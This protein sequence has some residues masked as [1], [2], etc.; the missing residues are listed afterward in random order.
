MLLAVWIGFCGGALASDGEVAMDAARSLVGLGERAAGSPGASAAQGWAAGRLEAMG[1]EVRR[2]EAGYEGWV[3]GC[4]PGESGPTALA[5]AHTDAVHPDCPGAVDNAGSVGVALA[6]AA[7]LRH[8]PTALGICFA[9]PDGEEHGLLGAR[10]LAGS[11]QATWPERPLALAVAMEF[12]GN[13]A[14]VA[15]NMDPTWG[16]AG[17]RWVMAHADADV[18]FAYR[19]VARA[20]P[21][22]TARSDH[23]PFAASGVPSVFLVGRDEDG[24]YWPYHTDQDDLSRLDSAALGASVDAL[25]SL[26]SAPPPP[27]GGD[28]SLPFPGTRLL[29][30]GGLIQALTLAGLLLGFAGPLGRRDGP[31]GRLRGAVATAGIALL[32]LGLTLLATAAGAVAWAIGAHGRADHGALAEPLTLAWAG[33]VAAVALLTCGRFER[34]ARPL[35]AG[36]LAAAL[37]AAPLLWIDVTLGFA[38]SAG[39]LGLGLAQRRRWLWPLGLGLAAPLPI[40]LSTPDL[41]RE[42]VFQ[43]LLPEGGMW[44]MP[45]RALFWWPLLTAGLALPARARRL[46]PLAALAALAGIAWATATEP[47]AAPY[48]QR[49]MLWPG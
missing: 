35:G 40:Y 44:W 21:H 29:I 10:A 36:A 5:L 11:W 25:S 4:R 49:E 26:L 43:F 28:A 12:M 24:I 14:L 32:G 17:M 42:L 22:A 47:W 48:F 46:W 18:P 1:Y 31:E 37:T 2:S 19:V 20:A 9:F 34:P 45:G 23:A 41:W 3:V 39:A 7:R 6:A 15:A 38:F 27:A 30:P 8:A 13:G 33:A 16:R